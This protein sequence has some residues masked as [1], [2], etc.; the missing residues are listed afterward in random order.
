MLHLRITTTE[1][2]AENFISPYLEL[3]DDS[4]NLALPNRI[5][6]NPLLTPID[7]L[8]S[9]PV[10]LFANETDLLNGYPPPTY[11]Y[12][13]LNDPLHPGSSFYNGRNPEGIRFEWILQSNGLNRI[14]YMYFYFKNAFYLF[15]IESLTVDYFS[16]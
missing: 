5:K 1:Y 7:Y 14:I 11:L 10:D 3:V 9:L 8:A 2:P 4:E 6:L 13:A 15:T 12:A 16:L